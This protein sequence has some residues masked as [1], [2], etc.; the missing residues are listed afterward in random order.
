MENY[1]ESDEYIRSLKNFYLEYKCITKI[2]IADFLIKDYWEA[3]MLNDWS[4]WFDINQNSIELVDL[5]ELVSKGYSDKVFA[6]NPLSKYI[7][8]FSPMSSHFD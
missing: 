8:D 3:I 5:V 2:R 1:Y 4:S 6:Q 7:L